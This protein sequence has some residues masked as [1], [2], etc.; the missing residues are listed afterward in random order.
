[1]YNSDEKYTV[2]K[3]ALGYLKNNNYNC[4]QCC[5]FNINIQ[6]QIVYNKC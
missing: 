5:Y 2:K 6:Q 3:A 4:K 1:M